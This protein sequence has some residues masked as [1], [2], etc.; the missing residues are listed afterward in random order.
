MITRRGPRLEI[1]EALM[2]VMLSSTY[3]D[4]VEHRLAA[5][6]ALERLG[7][8][9]GR[10]EV[11]GA[12][13]L[14]P[15]QACLQEID[16]SD[17]FVGI[18]AHRYGYVP[19]GAA[20]S[21]TEQEFHRAFEQRKPLLCFV[22]AEDYPW[23]E[24][25]IESEPGAT[26]LLTFKTILRSRLIVDT[27]REPA[28]LALRIATA[29]ARLLTAHRRL[30]S[31]PAVDHQEACKRD[32]LIRYLQTRTDDAIA[33]L[34]SPS[35][36]QQFAIL[37]IRNIEAIRDGDLLLSHLLT[38]EIRSLLGLDRIVAYLQNVLTSPISRTR[39][40]L[41]YPYLHDPGKDRIVYTSHR[42]SIA[43]GFDESLEFDESGMQSSSWRDDV[44]VR[45]TE[46]VIASFE[47]DLAECRRDVALRH[48]AEERGV[49]LV[50]WSGVERVYCPHCG[51]KLPS[52]EHSNVLMTCRQC[53]TTIQVLL[54]VGPY[55]YN[56]HILDRGVCSKCG[57]TAPYI[58]A[59]GKSCTP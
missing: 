44:L 45:W 33:A 19:A 25:L 37:H 14:E 52:R 47:N 49:Q 59:F 29:F 57:F 5:T 42:H 3:L 51:A 27:F 13:P 9:V 53:R 7:H 21:I 41:D 40:P 58:K 31:V 22:V 43:L 38:A 1:V 20:Q 2:R 11:F 4:L 17:I 39:E 32:E 24:D 23:P 30:I 36:K 10:M 54:Q 34:T 12:R 26:K 56:G 16:D 18:Y 28:E 48:A 55:E 8:Q 35:A 46:Q 50:Q 6:D 15:T